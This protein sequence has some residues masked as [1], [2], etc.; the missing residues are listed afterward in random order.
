ME[1]ND[2]FPIKIDNTPS[3]IAQLIIITKY[4]LINYFRSKRFY[5]LLGIGLI[6]SAILTGLIGYYRPP[7]FITTP[8]GFYSNWLGNSIIFIIVLSA[9]FFGGDSISGEFQNKTGFFIASRPVRRSS[10]Y[11]GKWIA[12]FIASLFIIILF[13]GIAIGNGI[14][15]FGANVPYEVWEAFAFSIVFLASVLGF[16]FFFSSMFK[17]AAYSIIVTA[18][19]FLFAFNLIQILISSL[20]GIEPW[21]MITY[22]SSIISNVLINPYP[23]HVVV[24]QGPGRILISKTY[25]ATIVEGLMIMGG[26]FIISTILGLFIFEKREFN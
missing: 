13:I 2:I 12:S 15:Y 26:Y 4:E 5:I 19:L 24:N 14:Y 6:I 23:P 8:L 22:G 10:I 25:N 20:V 16:T 9:I 1:S 21:F 18:I 7:L 17:S 11:I 3:S